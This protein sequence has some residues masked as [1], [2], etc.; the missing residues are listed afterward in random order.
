MGAQW[1]GEFAQSDAV[2]RAARWVNEFQTQHPTEVGAAPVLSDPSAGQSAFAAAHAEYHF[3]R[4]NPF[5]TQP[6]ATLE[7]ALAVGTTDSRARQI[8]ALEAF[9]GT[10]TGQANPGPVWSALGSAHAANDSD[11]QAIACLIRA[12]DAAPDNADAMLALGT[13]ATN[14]FYKEEALNLLESWLESQPEYAHLPSTATPVRPDVAAAGPWAAQFEQHAR[15]SAL[16]L[17]AARLRPTSPDPRVQ[18]ALGLLYNLSY[19]YDKAVDCFRAAVSCAPT[20]ARLWN[21]LGATLANSSRAPE[22]MQ[23]YAEAL[24]LDPTFVR[25]HSNQGIAHLALRGYGDAATAFAR[26]IQLNEGDVSRTP[27]HLWPNLAIALRLGGDAEGAAAAEARD[28][29]LIGRMLSKQQ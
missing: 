29:S 25:A 2:P 6:P 21:K 14:D 1:A 28:P 5:R 3:A 12:L 27:Q 8:L 4:E 13:S 11:D 16:F 20:D 18:D 10:A 24:R 23:A 22:A 17:A 9:L 19:E 26:A 7:A 15:V